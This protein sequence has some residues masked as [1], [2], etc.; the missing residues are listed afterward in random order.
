LLIKA[1]TIRRPT[2]DSVTGLNSIELKVN[3]GAGIVR[4]LINPVCATMEAPAPGAPT[5]TDVDVKTIG[6]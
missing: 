3:P 1:E 2:P 5:R 4:L 6:M